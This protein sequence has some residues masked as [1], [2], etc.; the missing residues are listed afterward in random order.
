MAATVQ[1]IGQNNFDS[2]AGGITSIN[3]GNFTTTATGSLVVIVLGFTAAAAVASSLT[4][5]GTALNLQQN[6]S[7]GGANYNWI[8]GTADGV[9]PGTYN[10]TLTLS[11][12][13]SGPA[14]SAFVYSVQ[15]LPSSIASSIV[16]NSNHATGQSTGSVI[17]TYPAAGFALYAAAPAV[18]TPS[19]SPSWSTATLDAHVQDFNGFEW[20]SGNV[21]FSAASTHTETCTFNASTNGSGWCMLGAAWN[22]P[23]AP[24]GPPTPQTS[25]TYNFGPA[26][27]DF[28]LNAYSLCGI[29]RTELLQ[30]HLHDA[31]LQANF[32]LSEWANRQVNLWTVD[33][34]SVPLTQGIATYQVPQ[35]TVAVLDAYLSVDDGTG[36]GNTI[37]RLIWPISRSDY[38]ALPNKG[39]Q[40]PPTTYWFDRLISPT[41]TLWQVPDK[42]TYTLNY[43]RC[44]QVQDAVAINGVIPEVPYRWLDAFNWC[45]AARLAVMYAPERAQPLDAR[46]ERAWAYAAKQDTERVPIYMSPGLSGYFR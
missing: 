24:P 23:T 42:T 5:G 30:Q 13:I 6:S 36:T 29:K 34:Q 12:P 43:Y 45:L 16:T 22:V 21:Q 28:V 18:N 40:A 4:Y 3:F 2:G 7:G 27:S 25:G 46:A 1:Y 26:L 44:R 35:E 19:N 20:I 11:A 37:D 8:L 17:L 10:V 15:N 9:T 31:R 32:L 14:F 39:V 38:S 41:I 33:L